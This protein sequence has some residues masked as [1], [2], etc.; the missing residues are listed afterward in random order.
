RVG[1]QVFSTYLRPYAFLLAPNMVVTAAVFFSLAALTRRMLP[2][3]VGAVVVLL[4]Y[5]MAVNLAGDVER[6]TLAAFVDPFGLE[7][8]DDVTHYW[9]VAEKNARPIGL[10]GHFLA[11]RAVWLSAALALL[12]FTY[13]RFRFATRTSRNVRPG[14]EDAAPPLP[15]T[16]VALPAARLDFS[17]RA[18]LGIF[19]SIVRLELREIVKSVV[20]GVLVLAGVLFVASTIPEIGRLYGTPTY[21]VTARVV[22]IVGGSFGVFLLAI[23]TLYAGEVVWRE[24]D[25]RIAQITDALPTS[26]AVVV[27]AK[28]VALVM[29]EAILLCLVLAAS[30]TIQ[31]AKGYTNFEL[32]LYLKTLFGIQF[33]NLVC[34]CCLALLV[35]VLADHKYVGHFAMIV[36][37]AVSLLLPSM[38]AE[39]HLYRFASAPPHP[40]SDMN[41][42]GHFAAPLFWFE[43]YWSAM[44]AILALA[45]GLFWVRGTPSRFRA[46]WNEAKRRFPAVAM[47]LAAA[48]AV[49]SGGYIHWNTHVRNVYRNAYARDELVADYERLYKEKLSAV[50]QPRITA[51]SLKV[52]LYPEERRVEIEGE[53]E[54]RNGNP[55]LVDRIIVR[56]PRTATV[57]KV[58]LE[59]G[60]AEEISDKDRGVYVYRLDRPLAPGARTRMSYAITYANRGFED[61][62]TDTRIVENG[63]FLDVDYFPGLGYTDHTE[64]IDDEVRRKHRLAPRERYRDLDD[65]EGVKDNYAFRDSDFIGFEATVSTSL[66]QRVVAPG[67]LQREWV[68]SGRRHFRFA[69]AR[70]IFNHY[71]FL[72]ARYAVLTDRFRN[73]DIEIDYHPAHAY[74]LKSMVSSIKASLEYCTS[75]FS[76]YQYRVIRIVEFPGY[77]TF[78][79]SFPSTIPYSESVGFIAKVERDT[80]DAIDYPYYITAHEVA[81]QW[82]GHQVVSADVQGSTVLVETLAQYSA[83]MVMKRAYGPLAMRR[84]LHY[85]LDRYLSGRGAEK[86]KE[87]PLLRVED[88]GYIHYNKGSLVMY[89]LQ[90]LLGEDAVNRALREVIAAH[91]FKGPPYPTS[92]VLLEALRRQTPAELQYVLTDDFER[93]TLYENHAVSARYVK[94]PDGRFDVTMDLVLKKV[95]A[96]EAGAEHEV[97]MDDVIPVGV[98]D[99]SGNALALTTRRLRSGA[100]RVTLVVDK[101]PAKAGIDPVD[102]LVDRQP[103]DN[104]VAVAPGG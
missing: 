59:G 67:E 76:P 2:V 65:P 21:P 64:L 24:R 40:Y 68:A 16:V 6:R 75:N 86:K 104:L 78:A 31:A 63:T 56:L 42:F 71:A 58:A 33:V 27:P 13:A 23:L 48:V 89:Q 41:G 81:H 53:D 74:D 62:P 91:A 99:A 69:A 26:R 45:A 18:R 46:R 70:P 103:D 60:Q 100:A 80:P 29:V 22:Q 94:R 54:L 43:V 30:V 90:D 73:V 72:S 97:P 77:A 55:G 83:L 51:V 102:E 8:L 20:F 11:N 28:L 12:G 101:V 4:G 85:D 47:G 35:H 25:V 1:P 98:I 19:G 92:R 10:T 87:L 39:N 32:G 84:F 95:H 36:Y 34:L 93:I 66:D 17:R 96:D 7:A 50:P 15:G 3:Y 5:L 88:Q 57:R 49:A 38:G 79:E 14:Q 61:G 82:W 44:A 9:S 37:L 52:D